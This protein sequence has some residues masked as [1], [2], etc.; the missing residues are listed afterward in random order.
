MCVR[1][2]VRVFGMSRFP[3]NVLEKPRLKPKAGDEACCCV[4][5]VY[6]DQESR[7]RTVFSCQTLT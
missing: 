7:I 3:W 6:E 1:L 4:S 2:C 5:C